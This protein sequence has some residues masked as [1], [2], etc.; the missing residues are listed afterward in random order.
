MTQTNRCLPLP[1]ITI[2]IGAGLGTLILGVGGRLAMHLIARITTGT[3]GFT[4][5]GTL[6]VIGLGAAS[7]ALGGLILVAARPQ[8]HRWTPSTTIVYWVVLLTIVLRGLR[9][10]EPLRLLIFMPLVLVF[11]IILQWATWRRRQPA[12]LDRGDENYQASV[13]PS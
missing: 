2:L 13:T 8:F 5:G 12:Q 9:P 4:V 1:V 11:G 3:G 10:L 6:T 7:G